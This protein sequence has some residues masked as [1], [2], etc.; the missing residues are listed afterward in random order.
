MN[1]I[2]VRGAAAVTAAL[3]VGV[4]GVP[5]AAAN[6]PGAASA[7]SADFTQSGRRVVVPPLAPCALGGPESASSPAVAEPGIRFGKG[8]SSC[9]RSGAETTSTA[10]G[11]D[12]ELTALVAVGG[13]RLAF[14]E[15]HVTCTGRREGTSGGWR[16]D[17]VAGFPG[18]PDDIPP[19]HVHEVRTAG[20]DVLARVT[21]NETVLP[22]PNDGSLALN[23]A[24]LRFTERSGITGEV[25]VGAAACSPTP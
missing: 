7:G 9:A 11:S 12:F 4:L 16:V 10:T 5:A 22:Q 3:A 1:H 18:L 14:R 20:G 6:P 8:G 13:P 24:H 25:V 15:W 17:G 21:F 19:N 2:L 23:L